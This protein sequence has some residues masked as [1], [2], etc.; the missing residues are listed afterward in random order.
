MFPLG[1]T[2]KADV[3]AEAAAR[4]LAVAAKPDSHDICFVADGDTAGFLRRALGEPPGRRRRR[5]R[6]G[7][8]GARRGVR[9]HGRAA[10]GAA[11]LDR[12]ARG[13]AAALR[14]GDRAGDA[15]V[16]VGSR[17]TSRWPSSTRRAR[18][19]AGPC[20]RRAFGC[21]AQLRAHGDELPAVAEP[22]GAGAAVSRVVLA[23]AG[24]RRRARPDA[25]CC[26]TAR[27]CS[28]RPRWTVR[29]AEPR[30]TAS[31]AAVAAVGTGTGVGSMPGTDVRASARAGAR[32][33]ARAAVPARAAGARARRRDDRARR[34]RCCRTS[35]RP[36]GRQAGPSRTPAGATCAARESYLRRGPRR[37]RGDAAGLDR[38]AEDP[39]VRPVDAGGDARA[40]QRPAR[41]RRPRCGARP[42]AGAR[43][44]RRR[45]RRGAGQ[46]GPGRAGAGAG[47]RA[48][49]H[50][51]A[52]RRRC[53]PRAG[54]RRSPPS[55]SRWSSRRCAAI[56]A[57]S[58]RP[59]RVPV[60]HTCVA[61]P[62]VG[63][64]V[65]SGF[66]ALSL[67]ATLLDARGRRRARARPWRPGSRCCSGWCRRVGGTAGGTGRRAR[68]RRAGRALWH[69]TGLASDRLGTV[70]VTPTCGLAGS[71]DGDAGAAL[72]PCRAAART[73]VDDPEERGHG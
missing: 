23:A 63:L 55:T 39:A 35:V 11:D 54:W 47:R 20:R 50:V 37:R 6:R 19:G 26:T 70:A 10:Q 61:A 27:A 68:A 14:A 21:G 42:R 8:R 32:R 4:G 62:P 51:G 34:S 7:A 59:V 41:A 36:G 13:R 52:A 17:T 69:R 5:R 12:P 28:A 48:V 18:A 43:R 46:A 56:A 44:G 29:M 15:T 1:D 65:R 64:L 72:R 66:R 38:P 3:R 58:R 60:V 22:V 30:R 31:P 9:V 49:A 16:T 2:V 33:G 67:D 45:A 57:A 71:S 73:L 53:P 24:V 25:S 40:A